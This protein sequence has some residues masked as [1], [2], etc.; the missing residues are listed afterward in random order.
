MGDREWQRRGKPLG[1][2]WA[3]Y[4][5]VLRVSGGREQAADRQDSGTDREGASQGAHLASAQCPHRCL[6]CRRRWPRT[7]PT[8]WAS[9][10][11]VF[12]QTE[13]SPGGHSVGVSSGGHQDRG[14]TAPPGSCPGSA[15]RRWVRAPGQYWHRSQP[16]Q[17]AGRLCPRSFSAT[18]VTNSSEDTSASQAPDFRVTG[19]NE[20]LIRACACV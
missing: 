16:W 5:P 3:G 13:W 4:R 20:N 6:L 10:C 17:Q 19:S 2:P 14:Q 8:A 1:R 12:S 7:V 11:P 15:S 9:L 18:W